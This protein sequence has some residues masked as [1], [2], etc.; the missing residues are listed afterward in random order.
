MQDKTLTVIETATKIGVSSDTVRR[1]EK[2]G[3]I[4]SSRSQ[5]NYRL[6]NLDEVERVNKKQNGLYTPTEFK[7][8]KSAYKTK[9]TTIELFTGA[10][11]T[12]LGL[13]NAGFVNTLMVEI[14]KN[15]VSTLKNNRPEW[16]VVQDDIKN[17][18]FTGKNVDVVEG[19]FPCQ[20]F[21]Y[22]GKKLG[23]EDKIRGTLFF[24]FARCVKETMPK[25]AV[26]ENVKGLLRHDNGKTLKTMVE[27]LKETGYKV[28]YKVVRAQYLDVAQKRERLLIIAVRND[29]DLPIL[30][31]KEKDYITVLRDALKDVPKS[32]GQK[33]PDK[34]R[35]IL[36]LVPP[37]GYW[38]DLPL[39]LQKEYM[40]ASFYMEGGKTGMARRLS[41][42]EP[43][44]TLTC[45]PA[46][47][48]TERCHP[49]ETRP[50][51]YKEYA[52]IQSFPD[53]WEFAG[54]LSSKYKQ[55]GN[56]VPVNLGYHLGR[57]LIAMLENK[58]D[59]ETMVEVKPVVTK[60]NPLQL[61]GISE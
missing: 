57:C 16:N 8:L 51:T 60:D 56:A 40:G 20:T 28:A 21:S 10:G 15:A 35:K 11:G 5:N 47:K 23:L 19:G 24:E 59:F 53:E 27:T 42:D 33:Y 18:T 29:L 36:E 46:Q 38:R 14:D 48:Q 12:A 26:G 13:E 44:L 32:E 54:S 34:K 45:A 3:L 30:F 50:L 9:Y 17:I 4:K 58:P 25:I 31:P 55:I 22:A 7:I 49:D 61:F 1:W 41:W 6:F 37:G 39:E 2:K 52:R 43:S